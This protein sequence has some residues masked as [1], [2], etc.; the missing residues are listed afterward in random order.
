MPDTRDRLV[1]CFKTVFPALEE[2]SIPAAGMRTLA[3]WDS[4]GM[5][6][7]VNVVEEEFGLQIPPEDFER[8]TS[9]DEI[10]RY[11]DERRHG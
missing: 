5:V 3:D 9:F 4:V 8:L 2:G 1:E 7:L 6:V 11:L 10:L